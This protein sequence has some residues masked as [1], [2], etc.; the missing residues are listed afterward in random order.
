MCDYKFGISS[1]VQEYIL[2]VENVADISLLVSDVD[3]VDAGSS[4]VIGTQVDGV[5][6]GATS[7]F[8]TKDTNDAIGRSSSH[9]I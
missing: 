6:V 1:F 4:S 8:D 9:A 5:D 2:S 7:V 3:C